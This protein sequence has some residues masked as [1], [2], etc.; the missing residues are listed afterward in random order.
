MPTNKGTQYYTHDGIQF[1]SKDEIEYYK[2]C[3]QRKARGEILNFE[4]EAEAFEL[5][6]KFRFMGKTVLPITYTPDFTVCHTDG[7][8][9]FV[10]IKGFLTNESTLKVKMFKYLIRDTGDKYTMLSRNRKHGD[11]DGWIEYGE[12]KKKRG[13]LKRARNEI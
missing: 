9:E 3:L 4:Y 13:E 5:Q 2:L 12:L 11:A 7:T 8:L 1:R 6:P 10:E